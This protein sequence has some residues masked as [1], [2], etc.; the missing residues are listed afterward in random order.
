[1]Q[2]PWKQEGPWRAAVAQS[3]VLLLEGLWVP[4]PNLEGVG[5]QPAGGE[6]CSEGTGR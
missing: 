3:S 1:M 2:I 6:G 5:P 4:G